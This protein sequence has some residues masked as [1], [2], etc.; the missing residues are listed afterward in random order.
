MQPNLSILIVNYNSG[1]YALDCIN[2]VFQ[3]K[4]ITLQVIVVDNASQDNSVNLLN[5]TFGQKITLI[6]SDKNLGFACANNLAATMATSEYYL[7]LNPDTVIGEPLSFA[8]LVDFLIQHTEM[9]MVGPAIDEPRKG[10]RVLPRYRYPSSRGLKYTEKFKNL[11]G[12][13]AWILGACML[14]KRSVYEEIAG[15]DPD[16][17]LYG[18]DVDICLRLRLHGYQIGYFDAVKIIHVSGASE[19]GANSLD[20]WLRKKRGIFLFCKKHFDMR[21]ALQLARSTMIKSSIYLFFVELRNWLNFNNNDS[22]IDKKN[23]LKATKIAARELIEQLKT[24]K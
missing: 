6:Q 14:I 16:Y 3:Q 21:D 1:T 17:F 19:I 22:V 11:P 5:E 24:T 15:F 7:L 18:E 23:R 12:D 20:K 13:I 8:H 2:S 4:S 10:K 9:G